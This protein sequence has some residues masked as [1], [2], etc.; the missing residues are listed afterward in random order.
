MIL[1]VTL[2]M[3]FFGICCFSEDFNLFKKAVAEEKVEQN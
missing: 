1:T 2:C 3:I